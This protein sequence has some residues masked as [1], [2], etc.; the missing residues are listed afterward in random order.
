MRNEDF[1]DPVEEIRRIREQISAR[2]DHDPERLF[3]YYLE[4]QEQFRDRMLSS[5]NDPR[6]KDDKSAA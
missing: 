1:D 3:R 6:R 4:F 5:H 2:F